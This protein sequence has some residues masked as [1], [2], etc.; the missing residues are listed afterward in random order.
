M[1]NILFDFQNLEKTVNIIEK[2]GHNTEYLLTFY[3]NPEF[4]LITLP[5]IKIMTYLEN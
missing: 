3:E 4:T 2:F 5:K 1:L